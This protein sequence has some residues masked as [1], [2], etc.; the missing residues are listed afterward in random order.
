MLYS[1]VSWCLLLGEVLSH[2]VLIRQTSEKRR[3]LCSFVML[4]FNLINVWLSSKI[5]KLEPI[6]CL[7]CWHKSVMI[8]KNFNSINLRKHILI[9]SFNIWIY[10][11]KSTMN[12]KVWQSLYE[13]TRLYLTWDRKSS[14][15]CLRVPSSRLQ[16]VSLLAPSDEMINPGWSWLV[17][18]TWC[19]VTQT[20]QT[21]PGMPAQLLLLIESAVA[22]SGRH[23]L[24]QPAPWVALTPLTTGLV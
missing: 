12:W 24:T 21:S 3:T 2:L 16:G 14:R 4:F 8:K 13:C 11:Y 1:A 20:C 17:L 19:C 23:T 15:V 5:L 10:T 9:Y 6:S 22:A 7:L 18:V